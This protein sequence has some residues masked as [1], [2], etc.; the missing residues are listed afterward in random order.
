MPSLERN[1]AEVV[2]RTGF[3]FS[4]IS[5]LIE[6]HD[7]ISFD[8]FGTLLASYL[9]S[10][11]GVLRY[12]E[13]TLGVD[14][15]A[16]ARLKAELLARRRFGTREAPEASL[17]EIYEVLSVLLPS[18]GVTP[19]EELEFRKS[20]AYADQSIGLL[21]KV[22][23]EK[24][25][26]VIGVSDT[27]L[28][29]AQ[30][31]NLLDSHGIELDVLY[32]SL[33]HRR[34]ALGNV[35][36]RIFPHVAEREGVAPHRIL[37]LVENQ[38]NDLEN[39]LA[40]GLTAIHVR[41]PHE[42]MKQDESPFVQINCGENT[43][44]EEFIQGQIAAR[45][46]QVDPKE[47]DLYSYGFNVCGPLLLGLCDFVANRA[48][49][50]E[51]EQ[52]L[53]PEHQGYIVGQGLKILQLPVPKVS[54]IDTNKVLSDSPS[55]VS[56]TE[57]KHLRRHIENVIGQRKQ[58]V[59]VLDIDCSL[60][61]FGSEARPYMYWYC[62][63]GQRGSGDGSNT[64]A[65]LFDELS[66][67][68]IE[69]FETNV[70][71]PVYLLFSKSNSECGE[72]TPSSAENSAAKWV[73]GLAAQ[74]VQR[75]ALDFLRAI[76]PSKNVINR[77]ELADYNRQCFLRL[78]AR[79]TEREHCAFEGVPLNIDGGEKARR[80][81]GASWKPEI[82]TPQNST[83]LRGQDDERQL[84]NYELLLPNAIKQ[85]SLRDDIGQLNWFRIMFRHPLKV[86]YWNSVRRYLRRKKTRLGHK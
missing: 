81:I 46:P 72:S 75:G 84:H 52:L 10:P 54:T 58:N 71:E 5:N 62:L 33:D 28:D 49:Q 24:G 38:S 83:S 2:R 22:A 42:C 64:S 34:D 56:D 30:L 40:T 18:H 25:K 48:K 11:D 51:V 60:P 32:T 80:T 31:S 39:A 41:A 26:R 17:N 70:V 21:A 55:A 27:C 86:S 19:G 8:V 6:N 78:T 35:N 14:G 12:M 47:P 45:M 16:A 69:M 1:K 63:I 36:G 74:C 20:L 3:T 23:R 68:S 44:T 4:T 29:K 65:Y 66:A 13:Q 82:A 79:P 43:L 57:Q 15:F 67:A 77:R 9:F 7:V 37:H 61:T 50:D 76:S 73:R 85:L 59:A 53:L